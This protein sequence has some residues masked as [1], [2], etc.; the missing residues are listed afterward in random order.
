MDEFT[1]LLEVTPDI[2]GK[3]QNLWDHL[4][5]KRNLFLCISGSHLGMMK[6]V[7]AKSQ[8]GVQIW[9]YIHLLS[10]TLYHARQG[11]QRFS[12]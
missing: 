9:M 3:L 8:Q 11:Q 4:L 5:S 10:P 1:C 7:D 2:A 6:R 12:H